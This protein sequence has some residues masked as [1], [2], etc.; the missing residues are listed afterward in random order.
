MKREEGQYIRMEDDG[1]DFVALKLFDYN[2][3]CIRIFIRV[4]GKLSETDEQG[5]SDWFKQLYDGEKK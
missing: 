2:G 1:L 5:L 3:K 4:D